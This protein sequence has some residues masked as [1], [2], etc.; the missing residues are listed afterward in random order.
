MIKR[1]SPVVAFTFGELATGS[2]LPGLQP[3]ADLWNRWH[4]SDSSRLGKK[5]TTSETNTPRAQQKARP[6]NADRARSVESVKD[7]SRPRS[8][9]RA[10]R[11]GRFACRGGLALAAFGGRLRLVL[12]DLLRAVFLLAR[13]GLCPQGVGLL[14]LAALPGGRGVESHTMKCFRRSRHRRS[15]CFVFV[16]ASRR[17]PPRPVS[18]D[19]QPA[20]L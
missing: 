10:I 6:R 2:H 14:L 5:A 13:V 8:G 4:S 17:L 9:R 18:T 15:R 11:S 1:Q 7:A 3:D 12:V 20:S 16:F 19:G